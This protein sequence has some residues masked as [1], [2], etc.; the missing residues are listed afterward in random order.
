MDVSIYQPDLQ[1][2]R[3]YG[4]DP[5]ESA[6]PSILVAHRRRKP[7]VMLAYEL[8]GNVVVASSSTGKDGWTPAVL[9]AGGNPFLLDD[10]AT[11]KMFAFYQVSG[12]IKFKAQ[13]GGGAWG[14]EQ[15]GPTS[16]GVE[17]LSARISQVDG[18]IVLVWSD[19]TDVYQSDSADSG[20]TW[21]TP[22]SIA[23][24][25]YPHLL[26]DRALAKRLLTYWRAD[27]IYMRTADPSG[28]FG[29]ESLLNLPETPAEAAMTM[30]VLSARSARLALWYTD[31]DGDL[32][33]AISYDGG[34]TWA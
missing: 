3:S 26:I 21:T 12:A 6:N 33:E 8:S 13:D 11:R 18:G 32:V 15:A 2:W 27:G 31:A 20:A 9:A 4:Y 10:P 14:S 17:S 5:G 30:R 28:A 22:S 19:G 34:V 25:T 23:A 1:A 7:V 24:G 16:S 29:A